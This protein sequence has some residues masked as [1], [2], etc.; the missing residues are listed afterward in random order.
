MPDADDTTTFDDTTTEDDTTDDDEAQVRAQLTSLIA[1]WQQAPAG[2]AAERCVVDAIVLLVRATSQRR[3]WAAE[4]IVNAQGSTPSLINQINA[5]A[6]ETVLTMPDADDTTTFDDTTTEDDTTDDDEATFRAELTSLID[7]WQQAP[8]GS[9]EEATYVTLLVAKVRGSP[10]RRALAAQTI[11][12]RLAL[13]SQIDAAA[14][15]TLFNVPEVDDTT[16]ADDTTTDDTTT[17]TTPR[18]DARG[19]PICRQC[20]NQPAPRCTNG[21]C[22]RCCVIH[23]QFQCPRHSSS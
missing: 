6:G 14:G 23:G 7:V 1:V 16:T 5:A 12:D 15:E 20:T 3:V 22:G 21:C 13:I 11:G 18:T 10:N 4:A 9:T 2:S 19:R 8:S 17:D